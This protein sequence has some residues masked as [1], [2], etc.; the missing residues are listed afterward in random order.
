ML[1]REGKP[2]SGGNYS[3][4]LGAPEQMFKLG[5]LMLLPNAPAT[6]SLPLPSTPFCSVGFP[7]IY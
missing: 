3:K 1:S 2:F 5:S 7:S 6:P 4:S